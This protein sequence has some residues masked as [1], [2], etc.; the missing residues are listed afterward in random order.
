M[1]MM[2][3]LILC[4]TAL[5]L[6]AAT[7]HGQDF[8]K[9]RSFSLGTSL[10]T[11][12]KQSDQKATNVKV[13]Y[14]RPALLQELTWWPAGASGIS[15]QPDSVER[16]GFSFCNGEL[17]KISIAY[18]RTSTAGLTAE[19]M[20]KLISSKYG[21]ATITPPNVGNDLDERYKEGGGTIASWG[22][23]KYSF[24]L[25][26]SSFSDEYGLVIYS[27]RVNAQA[28]LASRQA[29]KLEEQ[30]G[31]QK[32]ADRLKKDAQDLQLTREQH[33]KSFRP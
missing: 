24:E 10:A 33:Q 25:T 31:P 20:V 7:L 22:D 8:S 5:P 16:I 18:D 19:D 29:A 27:K 11:V 32:E 3:S 9:Y 4:F 21:P 12:L 15:S 17:Y 30:E 14:E 23:A 26:R 2:R 1:K 6:T 28:E 13:T